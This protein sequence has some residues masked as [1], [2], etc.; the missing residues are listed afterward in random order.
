[1]VSIGQIF[2]TIDLDDKF[3]KKLIG[4][5]GK[6]EKFGRDLLPVSAALTAAGGAAVFMAAKFETS[7][8]RMVS[9]A[10]V[11]QNELEGVKQHILDL[12]PAAGVGPQALA[13]AMMMISSTT[14]DTT[15]ALEILD[16][17]AKGTAAGLGETVDVGKALTAIVNSYGS[18]NITAARA[19]DILTKAVQ[20]GGAEATELAPVLA[21]VI[22]LAAQLGISF[23]QVAA[24][25]ATATK[26]GIPAAESVTQLSSVMT[27]MLKPTKEGAEALASINLSYGELREMAGKD[28][29]DTLALLVERFGDNKEALAQ[30]FG[31]IEALRNVMSTAGQQGAIYAEEV[32]RITESHGALEKASKA[33]EGTTAHTWAQMRASVEVLAIKLGDQL[34]PSFEKVI[35][36][37]KP[38][39]EVAV[40][41]VAEFAE[42]PQPV[43]TGTIAVLGLVAALGPVSYAVGTLTTAFGTLQSAL[44]VT[45]LPTIG[46]VVVAIGTFIIVKEVAD[47]LLD[48]F[49]VV[50]E[51]A[52]AFTD[53]GLRILGVSTALEAYNKSQEKGVDATANMTEEQKRVLEH[54]KAQQQ[55]V[56][57]TE[58]AFA[59]VATVNEKVVTATTKT[60]AAMKA[61]TTLTTADIAAKL[62]QNAT[63][64]L[65]SQATQ[66]LG[67]PVKD[68]ATATKVLA[69]AESMSAEGMKKAAQVAK[70]H[71]TEMLTLKF[72]TEG[73]AF[74]LSQA[75]KEL[76]QYFSTLRSFKLVDFTNDLLDVNKALGQGPELDPAVIQGKIKAINFAPSLGSSLK[77]SFSAAVKD[78]PNVILQAF[79]GGGDVGKA[80]GAHLGGSI[81]TTLG[82]KLGPKLGDV[83]GKSLGGAV[84]SIMGPIGSMVGS[85]LGDLGGKLVG[86][87]GI[88]GNKEIMKLNDLR[89]K[90]LETEG[91]FEALQKKLVGLTDQD[92]VKKIFDAKTVEDFN[93]AV[94]EVMAL[95]DMQTQ[96]QEKLQGAIEE[97]GIT[98]AELGPKWAQQ[99]MDERALSL[100]EKWKLLEAAGVGV[101][102]LLE[103]MGPDMAAF[104]Q[105]SITAGTAIPEAM[106][107]VVE[108]LI[109]SGQLLDENGEAYT[110]V[111]DAG[112]TFA[113]TMEEK[114]V[115]L[116][117]KI[118]QMVNALLGI[119]TEVNTNVNVH[120]RYTDS[121]DNARDGGEDNDP[122]TPFATGGIVTQP[123]FGL[124]GEAGPEAVIPLDQLPSLMSG[125]SATFSPAQMSML[126]AA[127]TSAIRDALLQAS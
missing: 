82:E 65:L 69:L 57:D 85:M 99:Q 8:T 28:L 23:E 48:L 91:G 108:K 107:G 126:Q 98:T 12:A 104:V 46:Y 112:V 81:G 67:E 25:I 115:S 83:L 93:G 11:S 52:T 6:L 92:L 60:G 86:K 111:E 70:D 36:A 116:L 121:G 89:D 9:L 73:Q 119:P 127:I 125:S 50:R 37:A 39:I 59:A 87:L 29:Q 94:S 43:Q 34:A 117:D 35:E 96:A 97:Y 2:G 21:N 114:F 24:N 90:F 16:T 33:V 78:L 42:L 49:P 5:G 76:S 32:K 1:V 27:A 71:A 95:L 110:S 79:Q 55:I 26:L 72:A 7:L 10:G 56:K 30:V 120:T 44:G 31:R 80:I 105:E 64:E 77:A 68:V 74:Q 45:L 102:T 47:W 17:A 103:K 109:E 124:V 54:F 4:A 63:T 22:P 3:S 113:T 100:L 20:D 84:G 75:D 38:L 123:T 53:L 58:D 40:G 101:G 88:G 51:M 14:S 18:A 122:A 19:A 61:A 106:R 15:V 62:K 13:E 118:T 66:M 41:L